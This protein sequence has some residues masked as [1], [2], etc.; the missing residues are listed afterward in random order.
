M[1]ICI[2]DYPEHNMKKGDKV[3]MNEKFAKEL[4]K[5]KIIKTSE[6]LEKE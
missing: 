3:L 2:K 4:L 1:Y 5:K 6:T